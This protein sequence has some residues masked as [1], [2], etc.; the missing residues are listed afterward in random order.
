MLI[1][2]HT[3]AEMPQLPSLSIYFSRA[4]GDMPLTPSISMLCMQIIDYILHVHNNLTFN[5]TH[6]TKGPNLYGI[7]LAP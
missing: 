4:I 7:P 3:I 5:I 2:H 1:L 6:Y